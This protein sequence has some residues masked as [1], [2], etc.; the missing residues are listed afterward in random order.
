MVPWDTYDD[1]LRDDR[2]WDRVWERML[3]PVERHHIAMAV[4]RRRLPA[5]LFEARVAVELARRW[6]RQARNLI[7]LY[8]LWTLFW[9]SL[10]LSDWRADSTFQVRLTPI[11]AAAGMLAIAA[12]V[13]VRRRLRLLHLH[14]GL[15]FDR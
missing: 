3:D 2:V 11:L 15:H 9:G 14:D 12:C 1:A 4:W 5:G 10:A 13:A 8:A 6:R 7:V